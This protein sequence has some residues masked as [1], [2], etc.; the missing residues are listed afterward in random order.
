MVGSGKDTAFRVRPTEPGLITLTLTIVDTITGC[1]S[2]TI[3]QR[4]VAGSPTVHIREQPK[5]VL[6]ALFDFPISRASFRWFK[7]EGGNAV[8]LPFEN[9]AQF[10]PSEPGIY[11]VEVVDDSS[12]CSRRNTYSYQ[13]VSVSDRGDHRKGLVVDL[14][15]GIGCNT[16]TWMN[17][18]NGVTIEVYDPAARLMTRTQSVQESGIATCTDFKLPA[19]CYFVV[20]FDSMHRKTSLM[21]VV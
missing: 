4:V 1:T 6:D 15:E 11:G 7:V 14:D 3:V 18:I 17:A 12:G 20:V 13:T 10:Y 19:G 5:G 8:F 16:I 9:K 21:I 2:D